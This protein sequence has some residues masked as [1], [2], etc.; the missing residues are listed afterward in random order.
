MTAEV[1]CDGCTACCRGPGR[2]PLRLHRDT[3]ID[4]RWRTYTENGEVYLQHTLDGSCVHLDWTEGKCAIHAYRPETCRVF[5]CR[6]A[7]KSGLYAMTVHS[8]MAAER[9]MHPDPVLAPSG[10]GQSPA[11]APKPVRETRGRGAP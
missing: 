2:R 5:D 8:R 4:P 7:L 6:E 3:Y 9:L 10:G 1:P 11:S